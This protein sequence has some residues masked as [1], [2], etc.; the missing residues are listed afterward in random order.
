MRNWKKPNATSNRLLLL[1]YFAG[2]THSR[3]RMAALRPGLN[4]FTDIS[5]EEFSRD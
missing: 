1:T 5:D 3:R 2:S 4:I